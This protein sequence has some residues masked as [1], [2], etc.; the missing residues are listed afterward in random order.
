MKQRSKKIQD[1]V[2]KANLMLAEK[3]I[4][5]YCQDGTVKDMPSDS[6]NAQIF[7]DGICAMLETVLHQD[8]SYKGFMFLD[9]ERKTGK[10]FDRKYF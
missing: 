10:E 8:N 3:S 2:D 4:F 7:K 5:T 9:G 6:I 1:I